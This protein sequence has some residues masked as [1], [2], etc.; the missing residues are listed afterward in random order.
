VSI[1]LAPDFFTPVL[2][3]FVSTGQDI[4]D[5]MLYSFAG[6]STTVPAGILGWLCSVGG[7][8]VVNGKFGETNAPGNCYLET[9]TTAGSQGAIHTGVTAF[10]GTGPYNLATMTITNIWRVRFG[11]T[12]TTGDGAKFSWGVTDGTT[13]QDP[14]NGAYWQLSI[15]RP[16]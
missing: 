16:F 13:L 3:N 6:V 1:D 5:D 15:N 12:N 4:F 10:S 8:G 11:P 9:S 2:P 7:S 14:S